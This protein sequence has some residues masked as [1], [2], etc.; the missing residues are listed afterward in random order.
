M[1]HFGDLPKEFG[2]V[3]YCLIGCDVFLEPAVVIVV[4]D[5]I[6]YIRGIIILM[7]FLV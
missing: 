4:V 7:P 1:T 5:D 2:I 3:V 6:M